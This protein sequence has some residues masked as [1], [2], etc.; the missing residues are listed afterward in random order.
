LPIE[1]TKMHGLGNDFVVFDATRE[2]L[3]L[4]PERVRRI[5]RRRFGIGCDQVLVVEP[6][7][8]PEVDFGYRIFNA[9]GSEVGQCGNGARC[10]ARFVREKGLFSG[11]V[12]RVQT[13]SGRL[14]LR[15]EPD[16]QVTVDMGVPSFEPADL[17]MN[18]AVAAEHY[19]LD[20]DGELVEFGAVSMGN[21]HIVL[22][23]DDVRGAPV[24]RLGPL[25][26]SHPL[27]PE[28]VNV[29]FMQ[30]LGR[31][32]ISVRVYE[33]GSGETLACGS[34]ACAA[35]A[36]GHDR[37]Y[38]NERV[39]VGLNGGELVIQWTGHDQPVYMT[40]PA[41]TVYEGRADL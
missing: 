3:A 38:L 31:D 32:R 18:V 12:L 8:S 7:P 25:L 26:E 35:V 16:G 27:F 22:E 10:L 11:D 14:E 40:G 21:P 13:R 1:F 23:V 41:V 20:V 2:P 15:I 34:G 33:R 19:R 4:D 9:D 17:P 24:E 28:R 30:R 39:T 29:G 37:G 6:P 5:A 36:V